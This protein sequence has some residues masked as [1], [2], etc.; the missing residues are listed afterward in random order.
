MKPE[1]EEYL[2]KMA[3]GYVSFFRGN[4]PYTFADR[5]DIG[6][7]PDELLYTPLV[8]C[9]MDKF[10]DETY[11]NTKTEVDD[12]LERSSSAVS[13]FVFPTLNNSKSKIIGT[14]STDGLNRFLATFKNYKTETL[15]KINKQ[16]FNGKIKKEDLNN[17]IVETDNKSISGNI[18]NLKYLEKFSTK[19]YTCLNNINKLYGDDASTSFVYSNLVKAG[20]IELFAEV[21][22]EN[23][24]LEYEA[25]GS[26]NIN[27][28]TKDSV[29]GK[30]F[31]QYKKEKLDLKLFNPATYILIT[32]GGEDGEDIPEIKQKV[33]REVFNNSV[34]KTGKFLKIV[35]GS[36]V[37]NEGVTLENVKEVHIL[38]VHYNLG[39]VE[40]VI[41]RAIRMC[42]HQNVIND[43][44]R[45]PKVN[46]Y[47]YVISKGNNKL[48]S[49]EN[50]YR[51]AELKFLLVKKVE[52]TL[53]KVA[54]DCPLLLNGNMFPEEV[55]KYKDCK[56]PTLENKKKDIKYVQQFVILK[57][58]ILNVMKKI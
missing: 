39:K 5:V 26:Y 49:D 8:R 48:T 46:V 23:G 19:F 2:K 34:N 33:I 37:M 50:L 10:Q 14:Y 58:V 28:N 43:N 4:M 35:L 45:F 13:N 55:E 54:I 20:G 6:E 22:K 27:E 52:R 15:N 30:T 51:K 56:Y 12:S 24:Y 17:F 47:R 11:D 44:Y 42:K 3:K 57:N 31:E 40:Q 1:G 9:K 25:N 7:I 38:D 53:K 16:I 41:G 18:L 29:T 32:G 21:L 36:K